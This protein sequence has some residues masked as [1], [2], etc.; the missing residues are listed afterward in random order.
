MIAALIEMRNKKKSD[1][2]LTEETDQKLQCI[3]NFFQ[4]SMFE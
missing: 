1:E 3:F 2:S 4:F